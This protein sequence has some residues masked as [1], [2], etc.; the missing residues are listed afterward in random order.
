MSDA[1]FTNLFCRQ[2]HRADC[3]REPL[4]RFASPISFRSGATIFVQGERADTAYGLSEGIVQLYKSLP[5]GQRQV[6]AFALPGDFLE[7]PLVEKHGHSASAIGEVTLSRFSRDDL[8]GLADSATPF[9]A[10]LNRS[11]LRELGTARDQ[12]A[13]L[14]QNSAEKRITAF[15]LNWQIRLSHYEALRR[16]KSRRTPPCRL[17]LPMRRQDIADFTGLTIETVCRTL[18]E[19]ERKNVIRLVTHG[20][21][22]IARPSDV[23]RR[24]EQP[25]TR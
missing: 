6:L 11:M 12:L 7:T 23:S 13:L 21:L 2:S 9:L 19:L 20:V 16:P 17:P 4:K 24:L 14:G 5:N 15:L 1:V 10:L 18:A 8:A 3:F 22:L 25:G